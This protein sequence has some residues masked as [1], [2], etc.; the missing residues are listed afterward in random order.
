MSLPAWVHTGEA[1]ELPD[2]LVRAV[3]PLASAGVQARGYW[4]IAI[5]GGSVV[6]KLL[7]PLA[8]A[9]LPWDRVHVFWCDE[10]AVP[11][12]DPESNWGQARRVWAQVPGMHLATLHRMPADRSDL[13]N[14]AREYA[15]ELESV[16]GRPPHLDLVLLGVGDDGHVASL[17]P[18]KE[19]MESGG[20]TIVELH[21]P[22][23]PAQRMSLGFEVLAQAR[24]TCV[25]AFGRGKAAIV[26]Q[27]VDVACQLPVAR[28]LRAATSP[29]LLVDSAAAVSAGE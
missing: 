13:L 26:R 29:M 19:A 1:V 3:L 28:L 16:A 24:L 6:E 7:A 10:R 5:P 18:G 17:F 14:A 27:A 23:L 12:D 22:K 15:A 8:R 2:I 9:P 21:S 25:A 11:P 20:S 4:T